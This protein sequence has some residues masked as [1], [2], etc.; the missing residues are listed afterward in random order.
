MELI[1]KRIVLVIAVKVTFTV[2]RAEE[3]KMKEGKDG[4][5][6]IIS[7]VIYFDNFHVIYV[8]SLIYLPSVISGVVV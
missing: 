6:F 3:R 1:R 4:G 5:F 7:C 8:F 2:R